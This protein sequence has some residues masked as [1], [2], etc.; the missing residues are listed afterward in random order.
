MTRS[1]REGPKKAAKA[2]NFESHLMFCFAE[3]LIAATYSTYQ[4]IFRNF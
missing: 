2:R 1:G 4:V 3:N